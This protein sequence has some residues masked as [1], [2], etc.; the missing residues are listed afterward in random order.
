[1]GE[2]SQVAVGTKQSKAEQN[3]AKASNGMQQKVSDDGETVK[4]NIRTSKLM[5][6]SW[7]KESLTHAL[8]SLIRNTHALTICFVTSL[9]NLNR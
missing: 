6:V 5:H 2:Q 8:K 9:S 4:V 7:P 1:M 3:I